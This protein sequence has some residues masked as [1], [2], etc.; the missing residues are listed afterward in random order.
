MLDVKHFMSR[1]ISKYILKPSAY[2]T[3]LTGN[4]KATFSRT[5]D[6][7]VHLQNNFSMTVHEFKT[8]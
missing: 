7:S 5:L 8:T 4:Q 6:P 3:F 1:N 2:F